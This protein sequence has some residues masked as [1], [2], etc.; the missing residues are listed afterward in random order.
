MS[1]GPVN[2]WG[3]GWSTILLCIWLLLWGLMVLLPTI[4][5]PAWLM[6]LFAIAAAVLLFLGH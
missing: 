6:A 1:Q 5:V 4:A 3:R 2:A